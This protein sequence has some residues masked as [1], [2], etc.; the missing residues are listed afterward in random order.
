M[1]AA[2]L[3]HLLAD[4]L[5]R[6]LPRAT[7]RDA[8]LP[9]L[10]GKI[11]TV[12]GMRR[13]GKTWFLFQNIAG[14]LDQGN[15]KES[16]LYLNFEDERLHPFQARDLQ[17]IPD[18]FFRRY[19]RLRER[20]CAFFF[21]EVQAAPGW[22][23]FV[24][25]LL[26]TERVHLCLTGSSSRLLSHE[27]ATALRGRSLSTEIL[28][29]SFRETLRHAGV[30]EKLSG[31]PGKKRRALL[32]NRWRRYLLEGGFPEVQELEG[33]L[34]RRVLQEYLDLVILRDVVE[35]YNVAN[36]VALRYLIRHLIGAPSTHFSVHRFHND[37]RS[38]GI[39]CSKNT[40]HD[41]LSYLSDC[42]LFFVVPMCSPSTRARMVNPKKVYAIDTGLAHACSR[43]PQPDMGH[44]LENSVF[45]DLRRRRWTIEYYRTRG[46]HEVDFLATDDLSR[47]YLIQVAVDLS[48]PDTRQREVRALAEAMDEL[49]LPQAFLLTLDD[50]EDLDLGGKQV[51]IRPAWWWALTSGSV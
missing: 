7:P 34:R 46:G 1:D 33:T 6:D 50:D 37:L 32:E 19:P 2:L 49:H 12:I 20:E 3:D 16:V 15:P 35:R 44:L 9:W 17:R 31:R 40:L 5:E 22:E 29:F 51:A 27:V 38:Q 30:D 28:P 18:A 23:R 24:R 43:R 13:A 26:D 47:R 21:D 39:R 10:A 45:L 25:R 11:D 8:R 42:Y 36:V 41:F 4:F 14:W 48:R